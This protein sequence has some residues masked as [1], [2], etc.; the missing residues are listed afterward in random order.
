MADDALLDEVRAVAEA[1]LQCHVDGDGADEAGRR[2][3]LA[4]HAALDAGHPVTAIA[5]AE[6]GGERAAGIAARVRCCGRSSASRRS[7]ARRRT[8]M[9]A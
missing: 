2:A 1:R 4:A 3:V 9:S 7:C 8:S 5:A 6:A